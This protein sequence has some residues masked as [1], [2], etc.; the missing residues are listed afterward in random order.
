MTSLFR[1]V[2]TYRGV[3]NLPLHVQSQPVQYM[4]VSIQ[5]DPN[6]PSVHTPQTGPLYWSSDGYALLA[7][8]PVELPQD[9]FK[10][11]FNTLQMVQGL[12]EPCA[13]IHYR[14]RHAKVQHED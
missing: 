5:L 4:A 10:Q 12:T 13:L 8:I 6:T 2:Q 7:V 11:F 3:V 1:T 9:V 14:G